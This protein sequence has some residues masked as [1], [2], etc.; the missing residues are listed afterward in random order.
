MISI[1]IC[2][3]NKTFL[4]RAKESIASSIGV[5]YE[6]LV[7]DNSQSNDGICLVY[8]R[9]AGKAI[10][11]FLLFLHEDVTFH[12]NNWGKL[13]TQKFDADASVGVIGVA[14][15][16]YKSKFCSG[17]YTG[18]NGCDNFNITHQLG[19]SVS[20]MV[21]NVAK[22]KDYQDSLTLDGVFLMC[23]NEVWEKI[24]F[25]E[26]LLK[27][28]H[29][30]D[31]DFSVRASKICTLLVAMNIEIVHYTVGGDFGEKWIQQAFLYHHA[32]N[33]LLPLSLNTVNANIE[34]QI[35]KNWLDILKN[36][37][38]NFKSRIKWVVNQKL[39][40]YLPLTYSLFKFL[41]YKPLRL[42]RVHK[43]IKAR[44]M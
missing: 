15:A 1:V 32:N 26:T 8:N 21:T 40:K 38:I 30:Y 35:A 25:N 4:F 31:I 24:K 28:F 14:G 27:G 5:P 37:D 3:I 44:K 39:Y 12:T 17:W 19:S 22:G 41:L 2:S 9:L 10:Y 42:Y 7:W 36:Q 33:R 34:L 11:P 29:F 6:L 43:L 20:K 13:L 16:T 18:I 23:R